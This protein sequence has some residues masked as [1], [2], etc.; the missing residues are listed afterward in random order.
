MSDGNQEVSTQSVQ[1]A[2]G[3]EADTTAPAAVEVGTAES[4]GGESTAEQIAA[5]NGATG[6]PGKES[7]GEGGNADAATTGGEEGLGGEGGYTDFNIPEDMNLDKA[8]LEGATPL[9]KEMGLN[10]EQAQKMVDWYASQVETAHKSQVD[11]HNQLMND[12]QEQSRNDS[13]FGGDAFEENIKVAQSAV[14]KLGTPAL[15]QLLEDH[16][17]GNHPEVIRFMVKVGNLTK[18]DV[19][20]ASTAA[21]TEKQDHASL[22]YPNED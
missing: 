21:Q 7:G 3:A 5:A 12:W 6:D 9:L 8:A 11:A 13:E 18:E 10:Q 19:P 15:K 16:G 1:T 20:G 4:P 2:T 22:L 14:T 17:V